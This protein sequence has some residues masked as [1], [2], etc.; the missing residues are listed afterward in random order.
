MAPSGIA[1]VATL[2]ERFE[3]T[4]L[5]KLLSTQNGIC[6]RLLGIPVVHWFATRIGPARLRARSFDV[7]YRS[8]E[9]DF[10]SDS[11]DLA[12]LV[13][14][15]INKGHLLVLGCGTCSIVR[16]LTPNSFTSLLGIDLSV[17]AITRARRSSGSRERFEVGDMLTFQCQQQYDVVLFSE[18]L[19]YVPGRHRA[20]LLHSLRANLTDTGRVIV[21]IAE[22]KRYAA[23]LKAIRLAFDVEVDRA[24]D[25][26]E[27]HVLVFR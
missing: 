20:A 5:G 16:D 7:K 12:R 3:M 8:G 19:Y 6:N 24:L 15:Y 18:S 2:G 26:G 27:R 4:P 11:R 17:E 21:T 13:E 22:P 9:W 1:P 25:S 14:E 10:R 23:I